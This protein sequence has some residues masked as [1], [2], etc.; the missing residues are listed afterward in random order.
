MTL[1]SGIVHIAR[2]RR[3]EMVRGRCPVRVIVL[4]DMT[5]KIDAVGAGGFQPFGSY[6]PDMQPDR[7]IGY[8]PE[9]QATVLYADTLAADGPKVAL[10]SGKRTSILHL[11]KADLAALQASQVCYQD[12]RIIVPVTI[13]G[14]PAAK[15][16]RLDGSLDRL[17]RFQLPTALRRSALFNA[18]PLR[19]GRYA[20]ELEAGDHNE[21]ALCDSRGKAIELIARGYDLC[22]DRI[23]HRIALMDDVEGGNIVVVDLNTRARFAIRAGSPPGFRL[24]QSETLASIRLAPGGRWIVASYYLGILDRAAEQSLYAVSLD[25]TPA[26]W[27]KVADYVL[28]GLWL[29]IGGR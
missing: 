15:L 29:P 17:V 6:A 20:L 24:G 1:I 3:D 22:Y 11:P 19:D 2:Y 8:S 25:H 7:I 9:L 12:G 18:L 10:H 5:R 23:S 27:R 16:F 26:K 13:D 4:D 28:P 21:I 14:V